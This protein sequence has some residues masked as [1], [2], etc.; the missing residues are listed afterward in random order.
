[1]IGIVIEYFT[2]IL[3]E[4][5]ELSIKSVIINLC[6]SGLLDDSPIISLSQSNLSI[7]RVHLRPIILL[8]DTPLPFTLEEIILGS[9]QVQW[10]KERRSLDVIVSDTEVHLDATKLHPSTF[11]Q[12]NSSTLSNHE[13]I[14]EIIM[15]R[16]IILDFISA[17]R[18]T[19]INNRLFIKTELGLSP[20]LNDHYMFMKMDR[21]EFGISDAYIDDI[22]FS[23]CPPVESAQIKHISLVRTEDS[24]LSIQTQRP[25]EID[26]CGDSWFI[27]SF[28]IQRVFENQSRIALLLDEAKQ[29]QIPP[30]EALTKVLSEAF[31]ENVYAEVARPTTSRHKPTTKKRQ[32]PFVKRILLTV[33]NL[34]VNFHKGTDL[35]QDRQ[36][37]DSVSFYLVSALLDISFLRPQVRI[38][39][40]Q[41]QST[42]GFLED[43]V[44]LTMVMV[45]Q[46][47]KYWDLSVSVPKVSIRTSQH[48]VGTLITLFSFHATWNSYIFLYN[49]N[50]GIQFRNCTINPVHVV[51]TFYSNPIDYSKVL[52]GNWKQFLKLIPLC[53]FR[54][55]LPCVIEKWKPGWDEVIDGYLKEIIAT[56]KTKCAKKLALAFV[57]KGLKR[58]F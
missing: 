4:F 37:E 1:M 20:L 47:G 6:P 43:P 24:I 34:L 36:L 40:Q 30:P 13:E 50:E 45:G 54:I 26:L 23:I 44:D 41:V 48:I 16:Q 19:A 51:A 46:S 53:D 32:D 29:R 39:I 28:F 3:K 22:S 10:N 18:V 52:V 11:V 56:Q 58:I 55:T 8:L 38:S 21:V 12:A 9:V 42:I 5:L 25:V 27:L 7:T 31:V 33:P 2:G 49:I 15:I 14:P 35:D 57:K 17:I